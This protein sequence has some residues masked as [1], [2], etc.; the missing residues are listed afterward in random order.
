MRSL[1]RN[2]SVT[3][4]TLQICAPR[5]QTV[6]D[7]RFGNVTVSDRD[8]ERLLGKIQR[9]RGEVYRR[10]N[11]ISAG[12]LDLTGRH[13]TPVDPKSWHLALVDHKG[14]V[15][16]CARYRAYPDLQSF[17]ELDS[18]HAAL[19][20]DP[21]W[22]GAMRSAIRY[23]N[24]ENRHSMRD[25]FEVSGWAISETARFSTA[26]FT[27]AMATYALARV[28]GGGRG[29]T[30]ATTRHHSSRILRRLGGHPLVDS[31]TPLPAYFDPKYGCTM[32]LLAFDTA[33]PNPRYSAYVDSFVEQLGSTPVVQC[34]AP[35]PQQLNGFAEFQLT[36][37]VPN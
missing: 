12:D 11:A 28:L 32:E 10:D 9:F 14:A 18:R 35:P 19:A 33:Q 23:E 7:P 3:N 17:D 1:D 25:F 31:G 34:A 15:Q 37:T 24:L 21:L 20:S 27:M 36:G 4:T 5:R 8:H 6:Q 22:G 2:L 16:G 26:A 30:T 29:I 13:I